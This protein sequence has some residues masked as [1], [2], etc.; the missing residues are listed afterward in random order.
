M[1]CLAHCVVEFLAEEKVYEVSPFLRCAIYISVSTTFL[2]ACLAAANSL[3]AKIKNALIG[4]GIYTLYALA[5]P[6]LKHQ[7][8]EVPELVTDIFMAQYYVMTLWSLMVAC[9]F[10]E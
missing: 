3:P 7:G 9:F 8:T 6:V 4:F 2:T 1:F 5:A 10:S